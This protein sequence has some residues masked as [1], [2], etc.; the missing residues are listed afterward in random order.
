MTR[1]F[2]TRARIAAARLRPDF[3]RG[4]APFEVKRAQGMPG[5]Q[6]H[7]QSS[8]A[9]KEGAH[10]SSGE[11]ETS[12]HS[13]RDGFTTYSAISPVFGLFSHRHRSMISIDLT[14]ASRGQDHAAWSY[15]SAAHH[16]TQLKR[17]PLPASRMVTIGRTSLF[18]RRDFGNI[19]LFLFFGKKFRQ[20][21]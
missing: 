5:A 1:E 9:E 3:A 16:L 7:P 18:T 6:P 4:I 11:A 12:R 8:W 21:K 10:K 17:P 19:A 15:A 20:K 14:P 13:L 2:G